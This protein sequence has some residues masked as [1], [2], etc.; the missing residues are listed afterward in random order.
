MNFIAE[1]KRQIGLDAQNSIK[2]I[3]QWQRRTCAMFDMIR[4]HVVSN[5]QDDR[6]HHSYE[7][8]EKLTVNGVK[9]ASKPAPPPP[10]PSRATLDK[11]SVKKS[12]VA[13]KKSSVIVN[14]AS[15]MAKK[16]VALKKSVNKAAPTP[17]V[18]AKKSSTASIKRN[19]E[20]KPPKQSAASAAKRC[21]LDSLPDLSAE[22]SRQQS[23][24]NTP[25]RSEP[26]CPSMPGMH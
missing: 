17:I 2:Q 13:A 12:S 20:K 5:L 8:I 4:Q 16:P 23:P 6:R 15:V 3:R 18:P 19:V 22:C 1:S 11:S 14:K 9:K 10:P 26:V 24:E 25:V 21:R 7:S